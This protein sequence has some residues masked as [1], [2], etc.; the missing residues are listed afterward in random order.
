MK[1]IPFIML[2]LKKY[3]Y[4]TNVSLVWT[5]FYLFIFL[6]QYCIILFSNQYFQVKALLKQRLV[7][8]MPDSF[9]ER[10]VD[11]RMDESNQEIGIFGRKNHK[12]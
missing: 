10:P 8:T 1:G 7:G 12:T 9:M 2:L 3:M 6:N 4:S 11:S 5:F